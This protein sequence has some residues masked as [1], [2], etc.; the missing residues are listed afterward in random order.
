MS[1]FFNLSTLFSL[2]KVPLI[3]TT[4]DNICEKHLQF[5]LSPQVVE[6]G[7]LLCCKLSFLQWLKKH[8]CIF[9]STIIKALVVQYK[10]QCLKKEQRANGYLCFVYGSC[11][12]HWAIDTKR[13]L[14]RF[15][16]IWVAQS[17]LNGRWAHRGYTGLSRN[18]RYLWADK[19][20]S[21]CHHS[22][23]ERKHTALLEFFYLNPVTKS[24]L[25]STALGKKNLQWT[26]PQL[27]S[28]MYV[29]ASVRQHF[30]FILF[31]IFW[32]LVFLVF[33]FPTQ[34]SKA[35]SCNTNQN[36]YSVLL[37][38][39]WTLNKG[40]VRL[41]YTESEEDF[42][43]KLPH[44]FWLPQTVLQLSAASSKN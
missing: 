40:K 38:L 11:Q 8:L 3:H 42:A 7:L 10:S 43:N 27:L 17:M 2:W 21:V 33:L 41:L 16:C 28:S 36:I 25:Q 32:G 24:L 18:K 12:K 6:P 19:T 34:C 9:W 31:K 4:C 29:C 26:V 35:I 1:G 22:F 20:T 30:A 23:N 44:T 14:A 5:S 37:F 15:R 39:L 13:I